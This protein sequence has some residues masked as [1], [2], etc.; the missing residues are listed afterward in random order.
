MVYATA[1]VHV[2]E[3]VLVAHTPRDVRSSPR[4]PPDVSTTLHAH[5]DVVGPHPRALQR[6]W[7]YPEAS[8]GA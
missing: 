4:T 3:V 2:E 7:A 1:M 8:K 5:D 6:I